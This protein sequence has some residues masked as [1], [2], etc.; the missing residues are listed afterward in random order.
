M[1]EVQEAW[2]Q[3]CLTT[4]TPGAGTGVFAY[5]TTPISLICHSQWCIRPCL[6]ALVFCTC[7][8]PIPRIDRH[9]V[10]LNEVFKHA[11]QTD[12]PTELGNHMFEQDTAQRLH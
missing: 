1:V 7:V 10:S 12:N 8:G 9:Y 4:R 3:G 2:V 11:K 6:A 5:L